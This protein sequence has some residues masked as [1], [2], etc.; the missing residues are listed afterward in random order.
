MDRAAHNVRLLIER[1]KR[2]GYEFDHDSS[3]RPSAE[4]RKEWRR[5]E[6]RLGVLPLSLRA[7]WD[8]VGSVNL[9]GDHDLLSASAGPPNS[10]LGTLLTDPLVVYG[11]EASLSDFEL[12]EGWEADR[13][14]IL[15]PDRY[16]KHGFSGGS[17]YAI[18]V[19]CRAA[20][21]LVLN[22]PNRIHLVEYL[23]LCFQYGGF[24]GFQDDESKIPR[25]EMA[26]LTDGLLEI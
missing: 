4:S 12:S 3:Q 11:P 24:P 2:L 26:L 9:T 16:H 25:R 6:Q 5:V 21:A 14:C 18:A 17:E 10:E 13:Q 8:V 23:R 7:W 1:L 15:A 22:E 19:P 20:D